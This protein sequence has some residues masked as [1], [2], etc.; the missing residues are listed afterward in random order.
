M[1]CR[2]SLPFSSFELLLISLGM[3]TRVPIVVQEQLQMM[4]RLN[5]TT[6]SLSHY[7]ECVELQF[8]FFFIDKD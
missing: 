7:V 5:V 8:L 4:L 2:V 3:G 6:P 1:Q